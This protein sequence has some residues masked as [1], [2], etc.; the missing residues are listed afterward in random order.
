M[1]KASCCKPCFHPKMRAEW[2]IFRQSVAVLTID[3][4]LGQRV[5]PSMESRRTDCTSETTQQWG[6]RT[7]CSKLLEVFT[8]P[9]AVLW[10][11]L[12]NRIRGARNNHLTLWNGRALVEDIEDSVPGEYNTETGHTVR[13]GSAQREKTESLRVIEAGQKV[14]SL[15]KINTTNVWGGAWNCVS[16]V[17]KPEHF[18]SK[19]TIIK[20]LRVSVLIT[21]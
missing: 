9:I 15:P 13:S 14:R 11:G 5:P 18:F 1:K 19:Q 17:G 20:Q 16:L 2:V 3:L 8:N 4:Q 12:V 10:A 7:G 6:Q 21:D